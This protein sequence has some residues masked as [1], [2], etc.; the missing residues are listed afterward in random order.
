M[1][2]AI[3]RHLGTANHPRTTVLAA[4]A[5]LPIVLA[6]I[7]AACGGTATAPSAAPSADPA[8]DKL[9]QVQA[10]GTL[11][12]WT[13]LEY[14]PQ[15]FAVEGAT[16]AAG[17][18]CAPN[19]KTAPEVSGYDAETSKLVAA[20]LGVEPCFVTAPFDA[21]IAGSWGDRWDV[22]WAS[23]AITAS[24]MKTLHVTQPYYSTPATF[25]VAADSAITDPKALSGKQV[26]AC[27]GCTH[28]S[29]LKRTLTLPGEELTWLVDNPKIVTYNNEPPGLADVAAGKIDA[30]LCSEPVGLGAIADGVALKALAT[31]AF[32][33]QK[34][35]YVD[36]DTSL[37]VGPFLERI[38]A[39]IA[40]LHAKG[41][42]KDLS[43]KF[44]AKDYAA[45]AAAFDLAAIG[46]TVP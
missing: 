26:G 11:V 29:Y 15:S 34:T 21:M 38:D 44:F 35:G 9:A 37:A 33:T 19:E 45:P 4:R 3:G 18:K 43:L 30:F 23:G 24:R 13:D 27:A 41:T 17:T 22:A 31:P 36:R 16:R 20:A 40:D 5:V 28:E 8:R 7:V 2:P 12:L 14:P 42:L 39:V 25:F 10:R 32:F 46:Q 1:P 6:A